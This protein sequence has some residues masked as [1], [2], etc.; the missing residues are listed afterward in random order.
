MN[1]CISDPS[2]YSTDQYIFYLLCLAVMSGSLPSHL[3]GKVLGVLCHSRWLTL[4]SRILCLYLST[5]DPSE[6]LKIL[7]QFVVKG[8]AVFWFKV[9][10]APRATEAPKIWFS[11]MKQ[12]VKFPANVQEAVL[13]IFNNGSYWM[14]SE[15]VLLAGLSDENSLFRERAVKQ[16]IK[17]R[18]D[19][20]M[21]HL[22]EKEQKELKK[23]KKCSYKAQRIFVKPTLDYDAASYLDVSGNLLYEPP[24]T[25][26]LSDSQIKSF[27][28]K[29]LE[30]NV[31][32]HSTQTERMIR[33][34]DGVATKSISSEIREGIVYS[35]MSDRKKRPVLE[36]K[37]HM[38]S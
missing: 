27:L 4:G 8:Y 12:L 32:S 1:F 6:S 25:M 5:V 19:P 30:L 2:D 7:A 14:H 21:R 33:D 38:V 35:R 17:I 13:P 15:N 28:D 31:P 9:R 3:I 34:A 11:W 36:N 24:F 23:A 26:F 22:R 16:I 10:L 37:S 20:E 29:P 18:H